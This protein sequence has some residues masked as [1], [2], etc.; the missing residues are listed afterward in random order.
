MIGRD[1]GLPVTT[2]YRP[3]FPFGGRIDR[4]VLESVFAPRPG[5]EATVEQ[6][7]HHE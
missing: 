7:L 1:R 6:A 5:P 3:P 4:V 2:D